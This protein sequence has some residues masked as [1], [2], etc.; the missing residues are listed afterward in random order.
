MYTQ[1]RKSIIPL[2]LGL[3]LAGSALADNL[4]YNGS[5]ESESSFS[6]GAAQNWKMNDPDDH[7]DAW[8]SAARE[9]W[10]AKDGTFIMAIRGLWADTGDFGGVWQEAEGRGNQ[11]YR[12]TAWFWADSTWAPQQQEMKIEFWNWDRTELLGSAVQNIENVGE[13][14]TQ[15]E[16][17]AVSPDGTEW[18]RVVFN[19][20]GASHEGSLQIDDANLSLVP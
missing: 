19:V 5:F 8:G 2:A 7:G 11:T 17:V 9:N 4:L 1:F 13:D 15:R 20:S 12:L 14:W 6:Y 16:L 18:V 3:T 10:R